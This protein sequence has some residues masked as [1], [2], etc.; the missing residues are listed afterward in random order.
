MKKLLFILWL[1]VVLTACKNDGPAGQDKVMEVALAP[2]PPSSE[3]LVN[4][5]AVDAMKFPPPAE[6][7]AVEKKIIKEG[8]ITF[9]TGDLKNTRNKII[10]T[11]KK[12]GGYV[13]EEREDN[14]TYAKRKNYTLNIRVPAQ[15]F[16]GFLSAVS[17]GADRI[18]SKS[19]RVKDVTTQYIDISTRLKNKQLLE[20]RYKELLQKS[21][22][23][24]DILEIEGK[25]NEIRT[26]IEGTQGELNYLNKQIAYSSLNITFFT[27]Y[28]SD[29]NDGS[30][31]TYRFKTAISQSVELLQNIFFGLITSWPV[32]LIV[33]VLFFVFKRWRR[34]RKQ[35][36]E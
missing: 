22:K 8:D 15:Q 35:R 18:E 12:L 36:E 29:N 20:N 3:P 1:A 6:D 7:I 23:M 30:G 11:L 27:Q 17:T 24:A 19:I 5:P 9:E 34:K 10:D 2:P 4:K 21:A 25:L 31:F 14:N 13:D 32:I 33:V 26:D 16:E 28:A